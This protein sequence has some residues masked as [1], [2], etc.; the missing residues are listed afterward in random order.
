MEYIDQLM[1]VVVT[2]AEDQTMNSS[3]VIIHS[4]VPP[5]LC[6]SYQLPDKETA[7]QEQLSRFAR[8]IS[9]KERVCPNC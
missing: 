8:D 9:E 5:P 2:A 3:G 6:S 4:D 7:I 1:D